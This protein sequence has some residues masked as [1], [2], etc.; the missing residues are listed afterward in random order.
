MSTKQKNETT[1]GVDRLFS[2]FN[3]KAEVYVSCDEGFDAEAAPAGYIVLTLSTLLLVAAVRFEAGHCVRVLSVIALAL[4]ALSMLFHLGCFLGMKV[5]TRAQLMR[6]KGILEA[7]TPTDEFANATADDVELNLYRYARR[8]N[9]EAY[10]ILVVSAA[11]FIAAII[12][13]AAGL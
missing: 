13:L 3:N 4:A 5:R 8:R 1:Q 12:A 9:V 2:C 10:I 7:G 6:I 11:F